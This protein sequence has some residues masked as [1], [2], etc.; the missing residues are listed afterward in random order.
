MVPSRHHA[1]AIS[2][3]ITRSCHPSATDVLAVLLSGHP[4]TAGGGP[5]DRGY[6]SRDKRSLLCRSRYFSPTLPQG[7]FPEPEKDPVIQIAS[8]VTVHG[9]AGPAVKNIM[10]LDTCAQIIGAEVMSFKT[11]GQLLNRWRVRALGPPNFSVLH[12][13]VADEQIGSS[14]GMPSAWTALLP[15]SA[16]GCT[17]NGV[18]D[19][20]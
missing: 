11:E 7:H 16:G 3:A 18:R 10:T 14:G 8:L 19:H 6:Q 12:S 20:F 5:V 9:Q 1:E 13:N 4:P 17:L 15:Q 2:S